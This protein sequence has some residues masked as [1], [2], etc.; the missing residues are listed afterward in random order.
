MSYVRPNVEWAVN[1]SQQ[2]LEK[3]WNTNLPAKSSAKC[4]VKRAT[5]SSMRTMRWIIKRL[6][7]LKSFNSNFQAFVFHARHATVKIFYAQLPNSYLSEVARYGPKYLQRSTSK[8]TVRLRR[9]RRYHLTNPNDRV[10][11]FRI[12]A[13]L[14]WYL[15]SGKSHVGYLY[16]YPDN[17]LHS[18]V[19]VPRGGWTYIRVKLSMIASASRLLLRRRRLRRDPRLQVLRRRLRPTYLSVEKVILCRALQQ[20]QRNTTLMK[21]AIRWMCESRG[22]M[23]VKFFTYATRAATLL[24]YLFFPLTLRYHV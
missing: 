16:N 12:L 6:L 15:A 22:L 19:S 9:T 4:S 3:K 23:A 8:Q 13:K 5:R 10:E 11:L 2:L 1:E 18:V 14:L 7:P 24:I 21:I 20:W 17:P